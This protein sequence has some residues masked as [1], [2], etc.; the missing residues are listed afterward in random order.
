MK[1]ESLTLE[2]AFGEVYIEATLTPCKDYF[3]LVLRGA[4]KSTGKIK[5]PRVEISRSASNYLELGGWLRGNAYQL[6]DYV[7]R[8]LGLPFSEGLGKNFQDCA[9]LV[10]KGGSPEAQIQTAEAAEEAKRKAAKKP[11]PIPV[12]PVPAGARV[13]NAGQHLILR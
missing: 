12:S 4:G 2:A 10:K 8:M 9:E 5:G 1:Q 13:I 11:V 3:E 6:G 7:A